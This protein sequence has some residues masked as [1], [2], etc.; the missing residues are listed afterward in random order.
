MNPLLKSSLEDLNEALQAAEAEEFPKPTQQTVET[1][2]HLLE[3][4]HAR[5]P[6]DY[7]A[8]LM[9]N[10]TITIDTRGP[11]TDGAL[12]ILNADATLDSS[13]EQEGD[14]WHLDL[15][16]SNPDNLAELIEKLNALPTVSR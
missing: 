12:I 8:Y 2:K 11:G 14:H 16:D 13:G 5:A 9:H 4:L 1:A 6:R 15:P 3:T 7:A 10:G